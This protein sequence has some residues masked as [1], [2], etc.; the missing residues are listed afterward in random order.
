M[1]NGPK[2]HWREEHQR[3]LFH[4]LQFYRGIKRNYNLRGFKIRIAANAF[5]VAQ[6]G[7]LGYNLI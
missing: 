2:F 5:F 4:I 6:S 1:G 7:D 3:K